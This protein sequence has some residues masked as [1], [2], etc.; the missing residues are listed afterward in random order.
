MIGR[1]QRV[2]IGAAVAMIG[3]SLLP[4]LSVD[5]VSPRTGDWTLFLVAVVVGGIFVV[6]LSTF[7][8]RGPLDF[9]R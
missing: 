7:A 5:M 8:R 2:A 4:M 6:V 9:A 3:L 1:H